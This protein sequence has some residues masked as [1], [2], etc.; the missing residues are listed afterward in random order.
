MLNVSEAGQNRTETYCFLQQ[1]YRQEHTSPSSIF[2]LDKRF[3]KGRKEIEDDPR[4]RLLF[5]LENR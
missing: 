3:E 2:E 5:N 1:V 4:F